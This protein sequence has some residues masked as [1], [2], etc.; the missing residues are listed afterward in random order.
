MT[1]KPELYPDNWN[2]LALRCKEQ[3]RWKCEECGVAHGTELIGEKRGNVYRVRI[4]A[5]H[6]DH[7]P[8]NPNP[9]LKALCE[10]CHL[11]YDRFLHGGN[12]RRTHYRKAYEA[13]RDAGQID[14]FGEE[15][16]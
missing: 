10:A 1:W 5:A 12:A 16:S 14:L 7:D 9:R 15:A 11:K 3:A 13:M 2:E 8:E 4:T 6:M